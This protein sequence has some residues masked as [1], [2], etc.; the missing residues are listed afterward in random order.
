MPFL[1]IL[2]SSIPFVAPL[3]LNLFQGWGARGWGEFASAAAPADSRRAA[4]PALT[5]LGS[6]I[7]PAILPP[8]R[9]PRLRFAHPPPPGGF[10][11]IKGINVESLNIKERNL[12]RFLV[13]FFADC[14]NSTLC[15]FLPVIQH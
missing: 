4:W 12:S 11:K 9:P 14:V 1:K 5:R 2:S 13:G 15:Q 7:R 6:D 10:E 3:T 8:S